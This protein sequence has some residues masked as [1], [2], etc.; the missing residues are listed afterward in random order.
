[1][2]IWHQPNYLVRRNTFSQEIKVTN[3]YHPIPS[4]QTVP[5][6]TFPMREKTKHCEE[7]CWCHRA[8]GGSF[9]WRLSQKHKEIHEQVFW[10][11]QDEG[12]EQWSR[13]RLLSHRRVVC[14]ADKKMGCDMGKQQVHA[15]C[16][17]ESQAIRCTWTQ[18]TRETRTLMQ[19]L[20]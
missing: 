13:M 15:P 11:A 17:H 12:R 16:G 7:T 8:L 5:E 1:M 4:H 6:A 9:P 19:P 14:S 18:H 3:W 20:A 2:L 10:S